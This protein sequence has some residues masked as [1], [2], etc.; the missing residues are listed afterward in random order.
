MLYL[1]LQKP[2]LNLRQQGLAA[3]S[4][5]SGG[6]TV[7]RNSQVTPPTQPYWYVIIRTAVQPYQ[8]PGRRK[9]TKISTSTPLQI[10]GTRLQ[11]SSPNSSI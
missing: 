9:K 11:Y 3:A 4:W 10:P 2:N 1:V 8:V 5:A 7:H 6:Y